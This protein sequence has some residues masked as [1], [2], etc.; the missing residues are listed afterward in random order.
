ML[1]GTQ[2][3]AAK[4]LRELGIEVYIVKSGERV[5]VER[6]DIVERKANRKADVTGKIGKAGN[7]MIELTTKLGE[8]VLTGIKNYYYVPMNQPL[9]N[10]AVAALEPE[11]QSSFVANG[12]ITLPKEG[13]KGATIVPLYR[14]TQDTP[15]VVELF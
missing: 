2:K 11:T 6:Y 5:P 4:K 12:I 8:E 1:P 13:T 10:L 14:L 9:A 7:D 15:M 3:A